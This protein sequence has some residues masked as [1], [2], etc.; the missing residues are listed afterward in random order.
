MLLISY[1]WKLWN[2]QKIILH[3]FL[4]MFVKECYKNGLFALNA[5]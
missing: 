5:K 4:F 1:Y 3:Y 2:I